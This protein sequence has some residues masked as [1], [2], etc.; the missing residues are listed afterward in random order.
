MRLQRSRH[1]HSAKRSYRQP[2]SYYMRHPLFRL[3]GLVSIVFLVLLAVLAVGSGAH[4]SATVQAASGPTVRG[5]DLTLKGNSYTSGFAVNSADK[6]SGAG[7]SAQGGTG[8]LKLPAGSHSATYTSGVTEAPF[9]FTDVAP[10]WWADVPEQTSV[11]VEVRTSRDGQAWGDWQAADLEDIIM[12]MDAVTQTYAS[13]ISVPQ[14]ERTHR[15]VQSRVTLSTSNLNHTPVFNELTYTFIDAGVTAN[16]PKAQAASIQN[17]PGDV[18]KPRVVSRKD[19]GA[20]EGDSSPRW[21]A[22]YK[23]VTH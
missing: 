21:K 12:P 6:S 5:A 20:P 4:A 1:T 7:A 2:R 17:A 10:H 18:P 16:P 11:L 15:F 19:W 9:D 3:P 22:K 23:R 14:S 13:T 8:S